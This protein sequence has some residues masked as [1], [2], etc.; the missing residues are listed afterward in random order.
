MKLSSGV[1]RKRSGGRGEG[2]VDREV[3]MAESRILLQ[4]FMQGPQFSPV[5]SDYP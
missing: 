5:S 3:A 4:L 1:G 2:H